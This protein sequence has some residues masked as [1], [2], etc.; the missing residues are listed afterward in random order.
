MRSRS[1]LAAFFVGTASLAACVT[2]RMP[3]PT[4]P[5][6]PDRYARAASP[7]PAARA[8]A[9]DELV[10]D[11]HPSAA[12]LLLTL[13]G[14][15]IDPTVRAH[16]ADAIQRRRDPI[17][18]AALAASAQRDPDPS[19]RAASAAAFRK[20][21]PF[22][23]RVGTAAGLAVLCPGCGHFYL[24]Q[25]DGWGY[26]L[27]TGSL[28]GGAYVALRDQQVSLDGPS[29]SPKVPIGLGLAAF[30][31]NLWFYSIFD[32]YRDARVARGDLGYR[33]PISREPLST[34]ASAP[35]R[36]ST[37]KSPWVWAGV[38]AM[39]AGGIAISYLASRGEAATTPPT[40]FDVDRVNV[41]GRNFSRGSGFALGS[42]YFAGLFTSVGVGEEA[43]FRGVI[44][45]E[46]EERWGWG[47]FA[48]SSIIFGA[49][50]ITNFTDDART[51]AIAIPT[52]T[53]LGAT[54]GLAYRAR[55]YKLEVPV[56]MHFWYDFLLSATAF[57][58][59]PEH[60]P[61]VVQHANRW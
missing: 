30:A 33:I 41:L 55:G 42:A 31:Q 4:S 21:H 13:H 8:S 18:D 22:R 58:L 44:Q 34:L 7:D 37:L 6:A 24:D 23:K 36:P 16:A 57:A 50:H 38:P 14:R 53:A 3:A 46:L 27:T 35:F 48:L 49:V 47:G 25:P 15:D 52:I 40:I 1:A 17:L 28:I 32:A 45:T 12:R 56:A 5:P 51:A 10:H 60:Q 61:F 9:A 20:L 11:P 54:M 43:L 59:D 39:L 19:V 29:A 26:L 2:P